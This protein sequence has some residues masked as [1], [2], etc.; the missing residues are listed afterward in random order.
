MSV[1][2]QRPAPSTAY[3]CSCVLTHACAAATCPAKLA[4]AVR[5]TAGRST[6]FGAEDV[7]V[8]ACDV[9]PSCTK[10]TNQDRGPWRSF[11]RLPPAVDRGAPQHHRRA[12][13]CNDA[14][15]P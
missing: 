14:A 9:P 5:S 11:L 6:Q 13:E 15:Q 4:I 2:S 8:L 10:V 1:A 3:R 12:G 7:L